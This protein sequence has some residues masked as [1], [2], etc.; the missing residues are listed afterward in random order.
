MIASLDGPTDIEGFKRRARLLLKRHIEPDEVVWQTEEAQPGLWTDEGYSTAEQPVEPFGVPAWVVPLCE[1]ALLHR[2]PG[3]FHLLYRLL[4]RLV[5]ERD[6]IL[7]RDELDADRRAAARLAR[8]VQREIHKMRAFLRFFPQGEGEAL[9][10]IAWFEPEHHIVEANAPFFVRRFAQMRWAIFTPQRS[11]EWDGQVLRGGPGVDRR[12]LPPI[13]AGA[14]LWLTYYEHIFNPA[15]L[16][17]AMMKKEMP[18]RYWK[19]L[20]EA[21]LIDPLAQAAAAR[22]AAMLEAG[23]TPARRIRPIRT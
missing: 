10:H 7:R 6:N 16:K 17:L 2:D 15:R 20:P 3:R 8:E 12:S 13:D 23:P 21:A 1:S 4:W 9:R 11:I 22:G 5:C 18:R 14:A 19:N